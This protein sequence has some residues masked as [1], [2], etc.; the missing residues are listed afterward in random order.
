MKKRTDYRDYVIK[1]GRFIGEFEAMYQD[2]S[3]IPWHQDKTAY[4]FYIEIDLALIRRFHQLHNFT[5]ICDMGCGLG[6]ITDRLRSAM[7]GVSCTGIDISQT[8]ISQ[9]Q[10]LFPHITFLTKDIL[11]DNISDITERFDFVYVKD[12]LWYVIHDIDRF[13]LK[14]RQMIAPNGFIY[15]FQSVPDLKEFYGSDLFPG[16]F[17]IASFLD[18]YFEKQYVSSTYEVNAKRVI[19][20]YSKDKYLRFFG[21]KR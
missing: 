5:S 12:I 19:G 8:A 4:E 1:D 9:A 6:Y 2:S 18:R 14:L 11:L 15:V 3:D 10:R 17:A 16:T 20:N 7:R 13:I 21:C